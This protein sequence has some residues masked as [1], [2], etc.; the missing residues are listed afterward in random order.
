MGLV[1]GFPLLSKWVVTMRKGKR[2]RQAGIDETGT[3]PIYPATQDAI[4]GQGDRDFEWSKRY[5]LDR[6]PSHAVT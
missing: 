4:V 6:R 2:P 1:K 5:L 3:R